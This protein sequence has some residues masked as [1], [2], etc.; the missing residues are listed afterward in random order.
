M[1]ATARGGAGEGEGAEESWGLKSSSTDME[2]GSKTTSLLLLLLLLKSWWW[3]PFLGSRAAAWDLAF[4]MAENGGGDV[5]LGLGLDEEEEEEEEEE[6]L[7]LEV[8]DVAERLVGRD[9]K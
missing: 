7:L 3:R 5:G 1:A 9:M 4:F 8:V 2:E 6:L